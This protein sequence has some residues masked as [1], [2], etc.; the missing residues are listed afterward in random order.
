M[1]S[2]LACAFVCAMLCLLGAGT[3][4]LGQSDVA[5]VTGRV[6]DPNGAIIIE[7]AVAAKNVDTGVEIRV[8]TNEEGIYGF[9]NLAPGNYEFTVSKRGFKEILKPGVTLHLADTI[10]LNFNMEVGA[11]TEKVTVEAGATMI[12]T[13]DASVSTVVDQTYIKNMPL[14]GRSFQDL[15]LLTPGTV[16]TSPQITQSFGGVGVAGEF[17]VNGQR[18]ES[19]TYIIDGVSGNVGS[20][21]GCSMYFAGASGSLPA[22]TALGTTQALVSVDELQEFRVETSTYSA[23]YGRNPGGQI[24][25]DT[26]SGTNRWHGTAYDYIRNNVFDA[27]DWFNNFFSQKRAA[28]RQ[29]D[30]GGT[31]GGPLSVPHAYDGK[32]KTFF[33]VSYEGLRLASPQP[34]A[35]TPVPDDA[36]RASTPAPLDQV[37]KS[38]PIANGPELLMPCDPT[39]DPSCPAS[40]QKPSGLAE[41]IGTWSNPGSINSTSARLDHVVNSKARLF[42]RFND[43]ESSTARRPVGPFSSAP[44][45]NEEILGYSLRTY[46]G[47]LSSTFTN[48]LNNEFRVN[49]STNASADRFHLVSAGGSTPVD[50]QKLAGLGPGSIVNVELNF[51]PY[52]ISPAQFS[53][54]GTQK[55]WNFVDTVSYSLG[56][57]QI[58]FGGDY[59][60]LTPAAI[61]FNPDLLYSYSSENSVQTNTTDFMLAAVFASA[62]PRYENFSA[63]VADEWKVS[64]RLNLSLG[65][66]WEVNPAPGVT[67]G[68]KPFTVDM[69]NSDPNNWGLAPQNTPLWRT[70]WYNFAPR[71]GAAYTMNNTHGRETVVRAGGGVFFDTGNQLGSVGFQGPGFSAFGFPASQAFPGSPTIP[72]LPDPSD[73]AAAL[74]ALG[75]GF[76]FSPHLQ[77]PYTLQWNASIEQALGGSQALTASFVGSHASRLL[78]NNFFQPSNNVNG[79]CCFFITQNGLTSDFE[80]GQV[81]FRRRLSQGLTALTSYTWSHC[82]DYGSSNYLLGYQRGSC[83][84]DVRH[85]FSGAFSYDLPNAGHNSVLRAL[86]G[87][88]GLDNRFTARTAFPVNLVGGDFIGPLGKHF[89]AGL[90]LV[91]GQPLYVTQCVSPLPTGSAMIPCPGGTGINPAAFTQVPTDPNTGQATRLGTAPR[92]SV[93]GFGAWQMNTAIRR[94]FPIGEAL[95]LQ[96]RA[97]A[98]NL[99]NHPN[100]GVIDPNFGSTTFGEATAT[101]AGSLG[102][103]NSLYQQGGPRS[104]Q[105]ALKLVF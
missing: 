66:R 2:R 4:V 49:Y 30:F 100:F 8:Q 103:L 77:L 41:F 37:I 82:I 89:R 45:T 97:E 74:G 62:Y 24:V 94:E 79:A 64:S 81:Q 25:F 46:T 67:Q 7:A 78:A 32:D 68:L 76:G 15:I 21:A 14:N 35:V 58:K 3:S 57:H 20:A 53:E 26:K 11:V 13:T 50:L 70:A 85:N 99:F 80:S 48:R 18:T 95:K 52:D 90:D 91:P 5:S 72:T 42:F 36:L 96:F 43:T 88:W 102:G 105:F 69:S 34:A 84:F 51:G 9:A 22:A 56:R 92:N 60:R 93:R 12:N 27:P 71:L 54:T 6:L 31:L 87:H 104:M 17:S 98:F 16:T 63:F 101:L 29:N 28:L 19:N 40:G 61:P 65:L 33:F 10:S 75:V 1:R 83:D 39:S 55:Q 44:V 47:G 23:E 59:R 86:L 73:P 38:F